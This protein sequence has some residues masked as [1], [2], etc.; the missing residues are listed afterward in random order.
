MSERPSKLPDAWPSDGR[1][2]IR[3][4]ERGTIITHPDRTPMIF[5]EGRWQDEPAGQTVAA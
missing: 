2:K 3:N 5:K 4:S 1:S